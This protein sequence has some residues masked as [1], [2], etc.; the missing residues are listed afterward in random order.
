MEIMNIKIGKFIFSMVDFPNHITNVPELCPFILKGDER[1]E[2]SIKLKDLTEDT[3]SKSKKNSSLINR[4]WHDGTLVTEFRSDNKPTNIYA[5]TKI[6][7][8]SDVN[9]ELDPVYSDKLATSQFLFKLLCLENLTILTNQIYL[10]SS[11]IRWNNNG[12]LFTAPSGTGKS[13]Q[14]SLWSENENA[15]LINGDRSCIYKD[16][17]RYYASGSPYAGTSGIYINE[18]VPIK[19]IVHIYQSDN[20]N[21]IKLTKNEALRKLLPEANIIRNNAFLMGKALEILEDLINYVPVYSM[22]CTPD[23]RA[24]SCLKEVLLNE[25]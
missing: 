22:G 18:S 7:A 17:D 15:E 21:I 6:S 24:V 8:N 16:R 23:S 5:I 25:L 10:H 3:K 14:A 11:L 12:I 1:A 2:K 13:T 19:A 20:N 9:I 4:Y